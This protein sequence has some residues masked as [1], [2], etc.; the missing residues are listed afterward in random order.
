[1]FKKI[2]IIAF[3]IGTALFLHSCANMHMT[4]GVGMSFSGG[5]YGVRMTPTMNVGVYGGG[6]YRW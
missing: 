3:I 6:G 2:L 1:M 5:P 4:G